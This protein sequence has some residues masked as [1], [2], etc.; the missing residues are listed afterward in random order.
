MSFLIKMKNGAKQALLI[1]FYDEHIAINDKLESLRKFN[2]EH[3][4]RIRSLQFLLEDEELRNGV[5]GESWIAD[6]NMRQDCIV[7]NNRA[8]MELREYVRE[9]NNFTDVTEIWRS[10]P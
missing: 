8:I 2:E 1:Q 9:L 6:M 4:I 5:L 3:A 10:Y 7:L